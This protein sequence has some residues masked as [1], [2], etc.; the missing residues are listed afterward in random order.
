MALKKCKECGKEVSTEAKYCPHCGAHVKTTIGCLAWAV[1]IFGVLIL[2][3]MIFGNLSRMPTPPSQPPTAAELKAKKQAEEGA[4]KAEE[5][6]LKTPAGKLWQKHKDWNRDYCQAIVNRRVIIGMNSE[7]VRAA[8]GRPERINRTVF[9]SHTSEQ[10]VYGDSYLYFDDG[11][12]ASF[13]D[14]R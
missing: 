7:Q 5:Q 14:S 13:Q 11:V 6:Y 8:W 10:W 1:I 9:P 2:L 4:R 12:L 3:G